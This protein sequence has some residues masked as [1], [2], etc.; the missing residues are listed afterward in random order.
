MEMDTSSHGP[1]DVGALKG[2]VV[3]WAPTVIDL[4]GVFKTLVHRHP[5]IKFIAFPEPALPDFTACSATSLEQRMAYFV[6][7]WIQAF[8][9]ICLLGVAAT[10][11]R[12]NVVSVGQAYQELSSEDE[13]DAPRSARQNLLEWRYQRPDRRTR[14]KIAAALSLRCGGLE[15]ADA[16]GGRAQLSTKRELPPWVARY[17]LP[18]KVYLHMGIL[19]GMC[20]WCAL[21]GSVSSQLGVGFEVWTVWGIWNC[22]T[23][24]I[25]ILL[26]CW[27]R[28]DTLPLL[29]YPQAMVTVMMPVV[30][31]RVDTA[32]DIVVSALACSVGDTAAAI[33]NFL[34][35]LLGQIYFM[36]NLDTRAELLLTYCPILTSASSEEVNGRTVR[37]QKAQ[38]PEKE[39]GLISQFLQNAR[40]K[41]QD[42]SIKQT[43]PAR[44]YI[45]LYEDL[46]QACISFYL[47]IRY[48][49]G[50]F[51]L[52]SLMMSIARLFVTSPAV[53]KRV[54]RYFTPRLRTSREEALCAGNRDMVISITNQLLA[55][56]AEDP[57][58]LS[59]GSTK[60]ILRTIR[61]DDSSTI[62]P[63]LLR[64]AGFACKDMKIAGFDAA[65]LARAGYNLTELRFSG[66]SAAEVLSAGFDG[67]QLV[68]A[69]FPASQLREAGLS[70]HELTT[71]GFDLPVMKEAGYTVS[72]FTD[73]GFDASALKQ[74]GFTSSQL[75]DGGVNATL[76][77]QAGFTAGHL[78][79]AG[80]DAT[81]A[82][83]AGFTARQLYDVG[84]NA[85]EL[86]AA[87]F[88]AKL[89]KAAGFQPS[90]LRDA[91]FRAGPLQEAGFS[92]L[93]L[94]KGGFHAS[95][96]KEVFSAKQ[97]KDAAF[98]D[99]VLKQQGFDL[100]T[101]LEAGCDSSKMRNLGFC[102][103]EFKAAGYES[104]KLLK[105]AG[106]DALTLRQDGF[107][108]GNLVSVGYTAP[109]LRK[110]GFGPDELMN[111]DLS[112]EDIK[113]AGFSA[114][115][116][117]MS[118]VDARK[119][120][121]LHVGVEKTA[122]YQ[123]SV[124]RC[125]GT[126]RRTL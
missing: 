85:F 126:N 114:E 108:L 32:K 37:I 88:D 31:E 68:Q 99:M 118:G 76:Q 74:A 56:E 86:K 122:V 12:N 45:A 47:A 16:E 5:K 65:Q 113:D 81:D 4:V 7:L 33:L 120:L 89:L 3:V 41:L 70:V 25:E 78:R 15:D 63:K 95:D 97:L 28:N 49:L 51:C 6:S 107:S 53:A 103:I 67:N 71:F 64:S 104:A 82:K 11:L 54:R 119:L 8:P 14:R 9:I 58:E 90:Q 22:F 57:Q 20:Y 42:F 75:K 100:Q 123:V 69:H 98:D 1:V 55:M 38:Q 23:G 30:S 105:D 39:P 73:A 124:N 18:A 59:V 10:A 121:Q 2:P 94:K 125:N 96:L 43:C 24:L 116:L 92:A 27:M 66:F 13:D 106:F 52:L 109:A 111:Q 117:M 84:F 112:W 44:Q 19:C 80:F 21:R 87:G 17:F 40:S 35:L 115:A 34:V 83:Q 93:D 101:L 110:A 62:E 48:H 102:F 50:M 36:R 26:S 29:V 91:G 46:P 60:A 77:K 61:D 79:E 72:Q